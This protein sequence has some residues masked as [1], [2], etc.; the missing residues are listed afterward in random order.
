MRKR[1]NRRKQVARMCSCK[2]QCF[3]LSSKCRLIL[4]GGICRLELRLT[5]GLTCSCE[6]RRSSGPPSPIIVIS[7]YDRGRGLS[8]ELVEQIFVFAERRE[9]VQLTLTWHRFH[10]IGHSSIWRYDRSSRKSSGVLKSMC[11]QLSRTI[12]EPRPQLVQACVHWYSTSI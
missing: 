11:A 6:G 3:S 2:P 8:T 7:A 4:R 9:Q 12:Y 10:E 5:G 1:L